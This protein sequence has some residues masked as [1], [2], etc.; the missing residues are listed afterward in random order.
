MLSSRDGRKQDCGASR[1]R[2]GFRVGRADR[3]TG[4]VHLRSW[5]PDTA[6]ACSIVWT[7]HFWPPSPPPL[8]CPH[9]RK[10]ACRC[11]R[12]FLRSNIESTQHSAFCPTWLRTTPNQPCLVY[13]LLSLPPLRSGDDGSSDAVMFRLADAE[14][15][16]AERPR[17]NW[18]T[19][20]T[21]C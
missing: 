13:G 7:T 15:R 8:A 19:H 1:L 14:R 18:L 10:N 6:D 20:R 11:W 21:I 17:N 4:L 2:L 9:V 3:R 5:Y 12:S 16:R